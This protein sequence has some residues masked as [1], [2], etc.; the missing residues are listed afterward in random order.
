MFSAPSVRERR[1]FGFVLHDSATGLGRERDD[2]CIELITLPGFGRLIFCR[3]KVTSPSFHLAAGGP[4]EGRCADRAAR[5]SAVLARRQ[6]LQAWPYRPR[7]SATLTFPSARSTSSASRLRVAGGP[8]PAP[9]A[10]SMTT[11]SPGFRVAIIFDGMT[12]SVPS[13]RLMRAWALAPSPPPCAPCG[14][15]KGRSQRQ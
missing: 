1:I 7:A 3:G 2:V 14:A 15:K 4:R 8:L 6:R 11:R 9:P 10:V 5:R 13:A 12:S